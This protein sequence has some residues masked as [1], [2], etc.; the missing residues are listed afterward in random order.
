MLL[1]TMLE[2]EKS[3]CKRIFNN[4]QFT[5]YQHWKTWTSLDTTGNVDIVWATPDI[6]CAAKLHDVRTRANYCT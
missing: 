6:F 4:D 1:Q 3:N 5:F 2:R